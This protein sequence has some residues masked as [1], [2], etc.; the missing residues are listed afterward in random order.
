MLQFNFLRCNIF[1]VMANNAKLRRRK[2]KS[3]LVPWIPI[4][5]SERIQLPG[6]DGP[7]PQL[8]FVLKVLAGNECGMIRDHLGCRT[9]V[10]SEFAELFGSLLADPSNIKM[11]EEYMVG[12]MRRLA[13]LWIDSGKSGPDKTF[14]NP[15][16]RNVLYSSPEGT[17]PEL[18]GS[19]FIATATIKDLFYGLLLDEVRWPE[20]HLD[21]TQSLKE[22]IFGFKIHGRPILNPIAELKRFGMKVAMY[23]FA[24][25]LDSPFSRHL[26]RCD[27]CRRYFAY[28]RAR[29]TASK[30]GVYCSRCGERGHVKRVESARKDELKKMIEVAAIAWNE[31]SF[32]HRHPDQ[33]QWVVDK[34]N[35]AFGTNRKRKWASQN[36]KEIQ[37]RAEALRHAQMQS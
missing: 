21:G 13:D 32:S 8:S 18:D 12:M 3:P 17:W 30:R 31:W 6:H 29:R 5:W 33:R 19:P 34:A 35:K 11:M 4:L 23:W 15:S 36:L 24:R 26:T 16:D 20:I 2:S 37:E 10:P 9:D 25:L 1:L 7:R 28:S 14:D 22:V 27:E